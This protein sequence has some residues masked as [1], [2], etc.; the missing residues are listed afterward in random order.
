MTNCSSEISLHIEYTYLQGHHLFAFLITLENQ[1]MEDVILC[2]LKLS[3]SFFQSC[4]NM[5]SVL[6]RLAK[7]GP[8]AA[9]TAIWTYTIYYFTC[10]ILC[11][12][13]TCFPTVQAIVIMWTSWKT[14]NMKYS[15]NIIW[16]GLRCKSKIPHFS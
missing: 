10:S 1:M 16:K 9:V 3:M 4:F 11:T 2:I 7:W 12:L 5:H 14:K 13:P 8:I 6:T 15:N